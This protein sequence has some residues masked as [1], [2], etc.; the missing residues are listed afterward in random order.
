MEKLSDKKTVVKAITT[1]SPSREF[2][3]YMK[4]FHILNEI[5]SYLSIHFFLEYLIDI[6][7][8]S[9]TCN[10]KKYLPANAGDARDVGLIPGLG[11]SPRKGDK[12]PL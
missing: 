12:N 11:N 3:F 1:P 8:L 9:L 7:L 4:W 6:K 2:S 10:L 5:V